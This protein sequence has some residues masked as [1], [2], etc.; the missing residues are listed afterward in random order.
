M[1]LNN[2]DSLRINENQKCDND[3]F[4]EQKPLN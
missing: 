1:F 4:V 3:Q 2:K